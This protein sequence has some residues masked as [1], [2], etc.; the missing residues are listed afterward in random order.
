MGMRCLK[1]ALSQKK[2]WTLPGLIDS[3]ASDLEREDA[4]AWLKWG[5]NQVVYDWENYG[6]RN[7]DE[8]S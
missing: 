2:V 5:V 8:S 3:V 6:R 7:A 1:T 4:E